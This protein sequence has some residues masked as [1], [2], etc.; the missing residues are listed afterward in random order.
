MFMGGADGVQVRFDLLS[1]AFD[2]HLRRLFAAAEAITLGH[3]GVSAVARITGVSRRAI[4]AG[5]REL[6]GERPPSQQPPRQVRR[7]GGG[8]KKVVSKDPQVT[9]AL[10]G[11]IDA[12]S[13]GDP[14]SPLKWT[15]KSLRTLA[16]ELKDRGHVISHAVVGDLLRAMDFSLQGN[17]K[18]LEG[19]DHPDRDDQFEHINSRARRNLDSGNPVI[20]IDAKKKELVG[21]FKNVGKTYRRKRSPEAVRVYDFVDPDL[22]R[23]TPYGVYDIRENR[24]WVCV[25]TDHDTASFAVETIRRWWRTVGGVTYPNATELMITADGGGSNGS[26][27]RLW[28][29]ELQNLANEIGLPIRVCH[30]PPGTS[31]WNKI[32]HRMF[33]YI[34]LNWA[35][36]PL[37]SHEVMV[38]LI[39]NTKTGGGLRIHAELDENKYATGIK[40]TDEEFERIRIKRDSFHGEWNYTI[41][42]APRKKAKL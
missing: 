19:G 11:L 21:L 7:P 24:G 39:A 1:W 36:K 4:H 22:G 3:G 10:R 17:R 41:K 18:M 37:I 16:T 12:S 2:E 15:S 38:N 6:K 29:L 35:G 30:F 42:P 13:C 33:S 32:E 9:E 28:K 5:L 25:G 23:A 34:S 26:R 20:S 14:E 31:K 8:R 27:L 40:V